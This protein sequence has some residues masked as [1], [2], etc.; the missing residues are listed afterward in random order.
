M[1]EFSFRAL[2]QA[3]LKL[4]RGESSISKIFP[5][6]DSGIQGCQWH[7]MVIDADIPDN[8]A[9]TIF[10]YASDDKAESR[11]NE[12]YW[13]SS[14]VFT[15]KCRDALLQSKK[16]EPVK[17]QYLNIKAMLS[18]NG[19]KENCSAGNEAGLGP[20]LKSIKFYYPR[21]SYLRYLPAI[22]QRDEE[23]RRFLERFLSIFESSLME[24]DE[25][26]SNIQRYFDPMAAPDDFVPWLAGW[27]SL[28]L[29]EQAEKRNRDLILQ[30]AKIYRWKGTATGLEM[31]GEALTGCKCMVKEYENNVF[32]TYGPESYEEYT[33]TFDDKILRFH[34]NTSRTLVTSNN[35]LV[36]NMG[37][38][39][40][41]VHY[42]AGRGE[43][44]DRNCIEY[45]PHSV[46]LFILLEQE[47]LNNDQVN[48]L[49]RII[50]TFLPVFVSIKIEV[51]QPF[52]SRLDRNQV[53]E[54]LGEIGIETLPLKAVRA[55]EGY[56][57]GVSWNKI[58]TCSN[59]DVSMAIDNI[60]CKK[61]FRI[62][63]SQVRD[64]GVNASQDI[65][66]NPRKEG[67]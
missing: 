40:D 37:T 51:V 66:K 36:E 5:D 1:S 11:H 48:L 43:R 62:L 7:R 18:W 34:R 55:K 26:I 12:D 8:A 28:D 32:R 44:K 25:I 56:W 21:S 42:I 61:R 17:G 33:P 58:Q 23:S 35:A 63:H 67:K 27:L 47:S 15:G 41:E 14:A 19:P 31:L 46:A 10:F 6:L 13:N 4:A 65:E 9:V 50:K 53:R 2:S 57:D 49:E 60:T 59:P 38:Y 29:Y 3:G 22:Y 64:Y 39:L 54:V 24:S 16:G 30:A 20:H 52:I 45:Y